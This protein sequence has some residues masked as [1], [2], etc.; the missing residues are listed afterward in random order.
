MGSICL[1]NKQIIEYAISRI[2]SEIGI[3]Q[4]DLDNLLL[5][6]EAQVGLWSQIKFLLGMD[7]N[8]NDRI[9]DT[10]ERR[11]LNCKKESLNKK[12][13]FEK[14]NLLILSS[15]CEI[16]FSEDVENYFFSK[17]LVVFI[18][19]WITF[20]SLYVHLIILQIF[21]RQTCF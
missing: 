12:L 1:S 18:V 2:E 8:V 19:L 13:Q 9:E 20:G 3:V 16:V 11:L 14:N 21:C 6:E 15:E 5:L 10:S 7:G 17:I 4:Q